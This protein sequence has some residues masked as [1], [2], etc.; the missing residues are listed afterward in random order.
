ME[1]WPSIGILGTGSY[2]PR[3]VVTNKNLEK[4]VDL[5][6]AEIEGKT[7]GRERR[8]ALQKESNARMASASGR[9]ALEDSGL[10][11]EEIDAVIFAHN[12][13]GPYSVPHSAGIVQ[14]I[15]GLERASIIDVQSGCSS[16]IYAMKGAFDAI[17]TD[18]QLKG[19]NPKFLVVVADTM[20]WTLNP[21]DPNGAIVLSDGAFAAVVGELP[22]PNYGFKSFLLEGDGC[23]GQLIHYGF[24][25][26]SMIEQTNPLK[27]R[28]TLKE[29][30]YERFNM[31]GKQVFKWAVPLQEQ[32][33]TDTLRE[34]GYN[35][36][37][38]I[39]EAGVQGDD[40]IAYIKKNL[41]VYVHPA[42][43]RIAEKIP[44]YTGL[45]SEQVREDIAILGNP[46]S[47]GLFIKLDRDYKTG[48][49]SKGQDLI[50]VAFGAGLA[51]AGSLYKWQKEKP[52]EPLGI[53][54]YEQK[55]HD[56]LDSQDGK[57][58]EWRSKFSKA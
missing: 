55:Q 57:F 9:L 41:L 20:S 50:F 43:G 1:N 28:D 18:R 25:L 24:P 58:E 39:K 34:A 37:K 7:G 10:S 36:G 23:Q 48:F 27:I 35:V 3:T 46:S 26:Y 16:G 14:S 12:N 42:N 29:P 11:N 6:A 44:E 47:A 2:V 54:A 33:I 19:K 56:I 32:I 52:S 45:R 4:L 13:T 38:T 17:Y 49:L 15:L 31:K 22:E 53:T 51:W 5:T 8:W 30:P 40:E 21:K